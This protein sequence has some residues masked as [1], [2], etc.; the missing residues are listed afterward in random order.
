M[1]AG[2]GDGGGGGE[3]GE[4]GG[5]YG[6]FVEAIEGFEY[7]YGR[8]RVVKGVVEGEGGVFFLCVCGFVCGVWGVVWVFLGP[9]CST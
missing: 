7:D 3:E 6:E 9:P 2:D 1:L 8:D 4:G 5:K